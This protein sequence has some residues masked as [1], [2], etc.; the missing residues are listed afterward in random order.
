MIF[1]PSARGVKQ[2]YEEVLVPA[3][4]GDVS[5]CTELGR[6]MLGPYGCLVDQG[7]P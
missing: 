4:M 5:I 7:H 6:F 1:W 3:G 2:V